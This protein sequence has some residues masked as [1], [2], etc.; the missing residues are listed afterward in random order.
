MAAN[1]ERTTYSVVSY[2]C[3]CGGLDL[4]FRGGFKYH[5]EDYKRLPFNIL[6]A[7]DNESRCVET[8]N[9]YF[10][11]DHAEVMDLSTAKP[12]RIPKADILIGGFPCQEFSSCGP[13]GGLESERG[14]LYQ[15]LIAYMK[16]H[17]PVM[18]VGENVIN[19]ERMEKGKVLN[20][21]RDDLAKTGYEVRVWKMFAPDYGIPQRRT[22]LIFM[23]V[24]S[25]VFKK[26]GFPKE[27]TPL[28]KDNHRSVEWAIGDLVG[29]TDNTVPNQGE[30]FGASKAKKGNGQ[31]DES[32]KKDKPAYT[33]RANPKSRVQFH[34]SLE[35]RLT[36]R[37]CARIQTFP[38]DFTFKF[39]KTVNISQIGNAVPPML[40]YLVAK[41]VAEYL[42]KMEGE[43]T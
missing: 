7:Y 33:I 42:G 38:D 29:I 21:I 1:K 18:V 15:T 17:T 13:L 6:K 30:Y 37:E 12:K 36:V 22:R 8:Y 25:D 43:K 10:G 16:E 23:C 3:G 27:P 11:A 39:S 20:T 34:Y 5:N 26:Y 40:A 19:L 41:S 31:G 35:R 4:G 24:R 9:D 2:F 14:Q 32:N 28:F